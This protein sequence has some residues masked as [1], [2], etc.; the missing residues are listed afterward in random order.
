MKR[1]IL[2]LFTV[3]ALITMLTPCAQAARVVDSGQ[4]DDMTWTLYDNGLLTIS[5][6]G[7]M[8]SA[9][10]IDKGYANQI[11]NVEIGSGAINVYSRAFADCVNLT[12]VTLPDTLTSIYGYAF[13][14]C[15]QLKTINLENVKS[16]NRNAF[17]NCSSLSNVS[18]DSLTSIGN[19]A[20]SGAGLTEV[21]LPDT[22]ELDRWA[23]GVFA[24][25][26]SLKSA[27]LPAG[28][29]EISNALF[30]GCSS[31]ESIKIPDS[32]TEINSHSFY[33][34]SSLTGINIPAN[35]SYIESDVFRGCGQLEFTVSED[36]TEYS[37]L[38]G[39]LFNKDKTTLIAYSKDVIAPTYVIPDSVTKIDWEAFSGCAALS[40]LTIHANVTY[41]APA[42]FS[43]CNRLEITLS[44]DNETYS[45]DNHILFN[46]DKTTL[47]MYLGS[48]AS[49]TIPNSVT[50]IGYGAFLGNETIETITIPDN[51]AEIGNSVF[52]N[53]AMLSSVTLPEGLTSISA[54]MFSNCT[55][56]KSITL[57]DSVT[58]IGE[59][60]FAGSGLVSITLAKSLTKIGWSAF[61]DCTS[62]EKVITQ[63][64]LTDI[65]DNAFS[66]CT[67]LKSIVLPD[68]VTSIGEFAFAGSGLVNV[69][70]PKGL[71]EI[72][73]SSFKDC[74]SLERV[75]MQD[76]LTGI[77][78]YAF[79]GCTS[80]KSVTLPRTLI[81]IS[82]YAF[83]DCISLNDVYYAGSES[84]W[85]V[86]RGNILSGNHP[87][88]YAKI[89]Y[90][91]G[92][93]YTISDVT[94]IDSDGNE[95]TDIPQNGDFEVTLS[96]THNNVSRD[97]QG[98]AIAALY[99]ED[100]TLINAVT[101]DSADGINYSVQIPE[102]TGEIAQ[103]KLFVWNF[104][105]KSLE[106]LAE[107]WT[108]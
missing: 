78:D 57:P 100:G 44:D 70:L 93:P 84:D 102:Q 88:Q 108:K 80:L 11:K 79:S 66:G 62:L 18:L 58:S 6:D 41:I 90:G 29:T 28:T 53:C 25:C 73:N 101:A 55:S 83:D 87:L 47:V 104:T 34:C 24:N 82:Y 12:S 85:Q 69:K 32:V 20:F 75:I 36:N 42:V 49:Y 71:K 15:G 81:Y 22:L 54:Y 52:S 43:G 64:G 48:S 38:D 40:S 89:H 51:V 19:Y 5:G 61:E 50:K 2:G 4:A 65:R 7:Q 35:V 30:M 92:I 59:S 105:N 56:L 72:D 94:I 76:G 74:T 21:V 8:Y 37:A 106:P 26:T 10:W 60:A 77:E 107:A 98:T 17:Y 68:S 103:L 45:Y 23:W 63:D 16:I 46:K 13:F 91:F 67:S 33:G 3:F 14:G 39:V 31:L 95:T 86:L 27:T 96:L 9:P 1:R 99:S 97:A